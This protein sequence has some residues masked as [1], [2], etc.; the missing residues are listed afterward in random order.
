MFDN[1]GLFCHAVPFSFQ[2]SLGSWCLTLRLPDEPFIFPLNNAITFTAC[3]FEA[4]SIQHLDY[5]TGI[6]N[7]TGTGENASR[8][9]DAGSACT[10]HK[11]EELLRERKLVVSHPVVVHQNPPRTPLLHIVRP[12]ARRLLC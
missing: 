4:V 9:G 8:E 3:L 2:H 12:I 6:M 7:E 5:P 10:T 1:C 11:R